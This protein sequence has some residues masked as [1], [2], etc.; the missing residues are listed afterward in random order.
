MNKKYYIAV[1]CEG[2]ACA[3]GSGGLGLSDSE[4]YRFA[5]LQ[6]SREAAAAT[7]ALFDSGAREVVVWDAHG[8]GVN[9][10]YDLL[11]SRCRIVL[12]AGHRGRFV[13]LD[14]SWTAILFIGYHAMEGTKDAVLAHTFSSKAFQS[15]RLAGQPVGELAIDAAYAGSL[16]VPVLFCASDDK[17]ITEAKQTFGSIAT[18]ETKQSLSWT[19]AISRHPAAVCEDIYKTV[20]H[21]AKEGPQVPPFV[22]PSPLPVEIRFQRMDVAAQAA[23]FDLNGAPFSFADAFTRTGTVRR[24]QDLF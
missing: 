11:D 14:S 15:Y 9:L 6:A 8:C 7:R 16:G 3:V 21:A 22:L 17:C 24:I 12:G 2:V 4:Q 13:G 23:L 19:S 10:D 5:C 1:D 20:L 18:V